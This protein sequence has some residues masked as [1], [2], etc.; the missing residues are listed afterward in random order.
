MVV[1]HWLFSAHAPRSW[2]RRR[3]NNRERL[4]LL[5]DHVVIR[6]VVLLWKHVVIELFVLDGVLARKLT[7]LC[8][9]LNKVV[10]LLIHTLNCLNLL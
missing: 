4:L 2:L 5:H 9:L 1:V 3:G 8:G 7:Y 6:K 10:V